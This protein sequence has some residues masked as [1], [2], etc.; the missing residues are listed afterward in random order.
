M[1]PEPASVCAEG[2]ARTRGALYGGRPSRRIPMQCVG[3]VLGLDVQRTFG[4]SSGTRQPWRGAVTPVTPASNARWG[5]HQSSKSRRPRPISP[6]RRHHR[7]PP[8]PLVPRRYSR[9]RGRATLWSPAATATA[10][11]KV[12]EAVLLRGCIE[13]SPAWCLRACGRPLVSICTSRGVRVDALSLCLLPKSLS[14]IT[15]EKQVHL[16]FSLH[17]SPPAGCRVVSSSTPGR[18]L[19]SFSSACSF[20]SRRSSRSACHKGRV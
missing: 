16:F 12:S 20:S 5:Q 3:R 15:H 9:R 8:L 11:T 19:S 17:V 18:E 7:R 13:C 1:S 6:R 4:L 10:A 2:P 14:N